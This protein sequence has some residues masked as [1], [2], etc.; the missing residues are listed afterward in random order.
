MQDDPQNEYLNKFECG[1]YYYLVSYPLL[2][3]SF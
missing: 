2:V 3:K 1:F